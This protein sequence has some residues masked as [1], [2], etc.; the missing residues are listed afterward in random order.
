MHME[1]SVIIPVYNAA[2]TIARSLD[3]VYSQGLDIQEFEVICVDDC[4][5]DNS[6]EVLENY[7]YGVDHPCNLRIMR[8]LVNKRQGGGRNTGIK[9]AQGRWILFLDSDDFFLYGS[10]KKLLAEANVDPVPDTIMFDCCRGNGTLPYAAS[11]Y[12]PKH[13][14]TQAMTGVEFLQKIPVPWEPWLYLYRRDHLLSTG[15]LFVENRRF[16]DKDFVL[17]YTAYSDTI[18]FFPLVVYY[19]TIHSAQTT[20]NMGEDPNRIQDIVRMNYRV[21]NVAV[22][23]RS[24]SLAASRAI[25]GHATFSYRQYLK[26]YVWR[27]SCKDAESILAECRFTEPTGD[28]LVDLANRHTAATAFFLTSCKPFLSLVS[29]AVRTLHRKG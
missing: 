5:T 2:D 10:L 18:R 24:H 22:N 6:V 12:I 9:A 17:K 1:L 11:D 13:L 20:N 28:W 27:L 14:D 26:R 21:F 16:E 4:S 23:E 25:M 15:F 8:H 19:H 7:S 29:L 3:S